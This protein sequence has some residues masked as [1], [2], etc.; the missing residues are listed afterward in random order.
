MNYLSFEQGGDGESSILGYSVGI[1][2]AGT[3]GLQIAECFIESNY[4]VILKT[5]DIKKK[6][7]IVGKMS[8][9]LL[10]RGDE[11][12]VSHAMSRLSI[13]DSFK[14]LSSCT[15]V[16]ETIVE[17]Y[18][19]KTSLLCELKQVISDDTIVV[20]NTSALSIQRLSEAFP[21]IAGFHFFNPVSRMKLIEIIPSNSTKPQI[22]EILKN[23]TFSIGKEAIVVK[24]T[25]GFLVNRLL[26]P[27][28]NNAIKMYEAGVASKEEIDLAIKLGLN[29]SMGPF[30]LA[31][32]IGLDVCYYILN[33]MYEVDGDSNYRPA[34]LLKELVSKNRLGY[35]TGSG[36]YEYRKG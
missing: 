24:D 29:H 32:F 25:P 9:H 5:R 23:I 1:I 34:L 15:L 30:E 28:I 31:D 16:I 27:Q 2:G 26:L 13:T 12:Y 10:K 18:E 3:M 20:T 8:K 35:K 17:D 11:S 36:F 22:I 7:T 4:Q 21:G 6:E 14:D 19:K 33:E